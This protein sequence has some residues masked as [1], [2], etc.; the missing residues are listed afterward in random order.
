MALPPCAGSANVVERRLLPRSIR[1]TFVHLLFGTLNDG[2]RRAPFALHL[3]PAEST[4]HSGVLGMHA[5]ALL[6]QERSKMELRFSLSR[7]SHCAE[8][9]LP[10]SRPGTDY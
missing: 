2:A 9:E 8:W 3:Q 5:A 4:Q 6:D 7:E 10:D 1:L